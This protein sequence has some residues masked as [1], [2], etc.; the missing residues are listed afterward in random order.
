[1]S[2][3]R[4]KMLDMAYG[5]GAGMGDV[6]ADYPLLGPFRTKLMELGHVSLYVDDPRKIISDFSHEID[7]NFIIQ[8][9]ISRYDITLNQLNEAEAQIRSVSSLPSV[10]GHPVFAALASDYT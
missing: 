4:A 6:P 2:T 7:C 10:I 8:W 5:L 1:M 3:K 9:V